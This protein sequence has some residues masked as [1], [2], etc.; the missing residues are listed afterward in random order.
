SKSYVPISVHKSPTSDIFALIRS[1]PTSYAKLVTGE[2][3]RKSVNFRTLITPAGNGVDVVIPLESIRAI[4]KWFIN[5]ACGFFLGKRVAYP[6]NLDVNLLK[7]DVGNVSVW[8]K[9]HGVP[10]TVFSED[11][12]SGRSSYA[13][14]MIEL[15]A[16]VEL[17]DTIVV[18]ECP[19]NIGSDVEKNLKNPSQNPRGVSV[20]PKVGFKLVKQVYRPISKKINANTS[21]NKK[22]DAEPRKEAY[23]NGSLFWNVGSNSI[24]TTPIVEK[25]DKLEKLI[26]DGKITLVDDEDKPLKKVDYSGDHDSEV[27]V[28]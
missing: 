14:A 16:D 26:I 9:L 6:W 4:S 10:V 7:E 27:E 3:G 22:K 2:P 8:V 28:E 18:D 1:G 11:G 20:G 24:S 25:I 17:K 23:S 12:L 13:R 19:K 5:T 15:Q 21:G